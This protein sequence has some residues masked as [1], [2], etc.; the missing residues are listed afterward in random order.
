M[1]KESRQTTIRTRFYGVTEEKMN[2]MHSRIQIHTL[3]VCQKKTHQKSIFLMETKN[4]TY[5]EALKIKNRNMVL[6]KQTEI[7]D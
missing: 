4:W 1:I 7:S 5:Q 3:T 2:I 6:L